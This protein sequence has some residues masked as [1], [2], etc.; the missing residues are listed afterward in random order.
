MKRFVLVQE[1]Q[2]CNLLC[3]WELG[4]DM[5]L[6]RIFTE[7]DTSKRALDCVGWIG[8][9]AKHDLQIGIGKPKNR[10]GPCKR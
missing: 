4:E 3:K 9:G 10:E 1:Q 2:K 8:E 7:H 6:K 5:S